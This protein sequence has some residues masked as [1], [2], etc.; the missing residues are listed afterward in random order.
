MFKKILVGFDGSDQSKR[1]LHYALVLSNKFR[2]ELIIL[3]AYQKR[4]LPTI[5]S[6]DEVEVK[7][8]DSE[9]QKQYWESTKEYYTNVLRYAEQIVKNDWSLVKYTALLV[10]G[11]PSAEIMSAAQRNKVDL[12]VIGS[13]D[14]NGVTGWILGSTAKSVLDHCKRPVFVVK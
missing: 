10:E 9:L 4:L 12:I 7:A 5:S 3:T 6:E 14:I 11:R 1:A 2:S 8:I 13:R